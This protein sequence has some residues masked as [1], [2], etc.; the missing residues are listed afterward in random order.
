MSP[1]LFRL[2]LVDLYF[3]REPTPIQNQKKIT[4]PFEF[5]LGPYCLNEQKV[6]LELFV[7]VVHIGRFDVGHCV[8]LI[9]SESNNQWTLFDDLNASSVSMTK[10]KM[11]RDYFDTD[12][13][14][15]YS[16]F[17]CPYILAYRHKKGCS[18]S[19]CRKNR[20]Q[21]LRR[22]N[23]RLHLREKYHFQ[24]ALPSSSM[25]KLRRH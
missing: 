6:D 22:R 3:I 18:C 2:T 20:S 23:R 21:L 5:D 1:K 15:S 19:K 14:P 25:K 13:F 4:I 12:N 8:A 9:K 7:A 24:K 10:D 17:A 11:L 16:D